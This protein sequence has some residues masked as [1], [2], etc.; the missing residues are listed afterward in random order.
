MTKAG[1]QAGGQA[2]GM[3]GA[4]GQADSEITDW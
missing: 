4:G 1:G 2:G 3:T